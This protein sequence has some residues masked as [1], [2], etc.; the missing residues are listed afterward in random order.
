MRYADRAM[1]AERAV[2]A[3][4]VAVGVFVV[5]CLSI[6]VDHYCA[7]ALTWLPVSLTIAGM[8]TM[9]AGVAFMVSESR[10]AS[11]QIREEI[12][13]ITGRNREKM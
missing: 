4:F 13:K 2:T 10:L 8:F 12:Q 1:Q 3:F 6:A 11:L 7:N 5:G 9:L